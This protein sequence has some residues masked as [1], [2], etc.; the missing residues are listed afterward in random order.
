MELPLEDCHCDSLVDVCRNFEQRPWHRCGDP[1]GAAPR[2]PSFVTFAVLSPSCRLIEAWCAHPATLVQAHVTAV[3][4]ASVSVQP[5]TVGLGA[6]LV[7]FDNCLKASVSRE[8]VFLPRPQ[9]DCA[10]WDGR[11]AGRDSLVPQ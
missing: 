6:G 2:Q 8:D 11:R 4:S 1:E 7:L 10:S 9:Q 5:R 3:P